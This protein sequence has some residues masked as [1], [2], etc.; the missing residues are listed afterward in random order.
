MERMHLQ[1]EDP[2]GLSVGGIAIDVRFGEVA[3]AGRQ[4]LLPERA[5][6]QTRYKRTLFKREMEYCQYHKYAANSEVSF[7]TPK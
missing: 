7:E 1:T 6:A 2:E 3:I 4:Y 5:E